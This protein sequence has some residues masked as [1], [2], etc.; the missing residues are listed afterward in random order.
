MKSKQTQSLFAG[1]KTN[2]HRMVAHNY[3][4]TTREKNAEFKVSLG[5]ERLSLNLGQ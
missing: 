3:T 1:N 2:E 5:Y 4:P